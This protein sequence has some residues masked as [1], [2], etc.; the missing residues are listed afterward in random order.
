MNQLNPNLFHCVIVRSKP[1][2]ALAG[3][4]IQW[5]PRSV[6]VRVSP[7]SELVLDERVKVTL[8]RSSRSAAGSL[9]RSTCLRS[10][11]VSITWQGGMEIV[12]L[13]IRAVDRPDSGSTNYKQANHFPQ[14]TVS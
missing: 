4:V 14:E 3:L 10:R 12:V 13:A 6:S 8:I 9:N 7:P 1:A 5:G 2:L 11:V